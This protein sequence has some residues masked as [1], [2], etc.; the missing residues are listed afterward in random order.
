MIICFCSG[1]LCFCS[2]MI[3]VSLGMICRRGPD[4]KKPTPLQHPNLANAPPYSPDTSRAFYYGVCRGRKEGRIPG[5]RERSRGQFRGG[6]EICR[7]RLKS[8]REI[9]R[10]HFPNVYLYLSESGWTRRGKGRWS[11]SDHEISR[12]LLEND[13]EISRSH[14]GC[15][16]FSFRLKTP[17][18]RGGRDGREGQKHNE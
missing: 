1:K 13:R 9:S 6:R 14:R 10:G 3:C 4:E 11:T 12:G 18:A 7:G 17:Y 5:G 15:C 2:E 8:D 16:V